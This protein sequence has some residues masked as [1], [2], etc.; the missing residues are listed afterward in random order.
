MVNIKR[1]SA[2]GFAFAQIALVGQNGAAYGTSGS[3]MANGATSSAYLVRE[4]KSADIPQPDRTVIDFT[5]GDRWLGSYQYGITSLGSFNLTINPVDATLIA[6]V[7][8][9]LV[10][11]TTNAEWTIYSENVMAASL[12][13]VCLLLTWRMQSRETGTDGGDYFLTYII[14]RAWM[15]PKGAAPAYQTA[16][17]YQFQI[18]PTAADRFPTNEPFGANQNFQDNKTPVVAVISDNP[19]AMT[20]NISDGAATT[21]ALGY[22]PVST[23]TTSTNGKNHYVSGTAATNVTSVSLTNGLVTAAVGTAADY[24]NMLY[25]TIFQAI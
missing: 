1:G 11:Q 14:P 12:P 23:N 10:D 9:A 16:V 3:S 15:A 5:G 24:R 17:D 19:L 13:Q 21:F 7:T 4:P 6:L 8:G 2:H 22:R 20:T 18:T 25:E